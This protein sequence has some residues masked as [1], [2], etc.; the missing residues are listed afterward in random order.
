[1]SRDKEESALHNMKVSIMGVTYNIFFVDEYPERLRSIGEYASGLCNRNEREIYIQRCKD[2][3][4]TEHGRQRSMK[5][6]LR[7][8][9][10]HAYLE[11]SGLSANSKSTV[12][13]AQNEEMVEWFS[14]QAPKIYMTYMEVGCLD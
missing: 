7:H 4:L 12:T 6:T 9:I 10:L 1:M 14:I 13:W 8:E 5:N 3:D 11:E 2:E